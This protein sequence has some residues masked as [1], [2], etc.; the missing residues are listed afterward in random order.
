MKSSATVDH[1]TYTPHGAM[2][3]LWRCRK[4]EVLLDGPAGTGKTRGVLE[5]VVLALWKYPGA[6][7]LISRKIRADMTETV[8]VTLEEKV[9]PDWAWLGQVRRNSRSVYHFP[10]GS[11]LVVAGW[12]KPGKILSGEY[13]II[14]VHQAE[15]I[16]EEDWETAVSRLRNNVMPYQQAIAECNPSAPMHWLLQRS[17]RREMHRI[18]SRHTDNPLYFDQQTKELLPEGERYIHRILGKL[19]G[20][21]R[22]RLLEGKWVAAEGLVYA[23]YDEA[24]HRKRTRRNWQRF[25]IGIDDG[26]TNPLSAHLYAIDN[27]G[28]A[29]SIR[30]YYKREQL[31][32]DVL[33]WAKKLRR[34]VKIGYGEEIEAVVIDPSAAKLVAAFEAADFA[35]VA[36]DNRVSDGIKTVAEYLRINGDELPRLT[37]DPSCVCQHQEFSAYQWA[38]NAAGQSKD[39]PQKRDDHAMD[40]LRYVCQYL[41]A[42]SS[43]WE[44]A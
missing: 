13:D 14:V 24:V 22:A 32:E 2:D 41:D 34:A 9:M 43:S 27:D 11:E 7:A 37:F 39:V 36:A 44:I 38:K 19:T 10:N 30:E 31:P 23:I 21:R 6:R 20:H 5:K 17:E 15:E 35:V 28:R 29:H 40:E 42:T 26:Y 8:L 1:K 4:L 25:V 16:S 33:G 12:D 18:I 3:L